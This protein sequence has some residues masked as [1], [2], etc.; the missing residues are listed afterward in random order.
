M[1][2]F[3]QIFPKFAEKLLRERQK[4]TPGLHRLIGKNYLETP[5][6]A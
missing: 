1:G 6:K 5:L 4:I 3:V 2:V